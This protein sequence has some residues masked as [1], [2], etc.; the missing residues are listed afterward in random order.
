MRAVDF[1][2]ISSSTMRGS[3]EKEQGGRGGYG[4]EDHFE[5]FFSQNNEY[6]YYY[7]LSV[8]ET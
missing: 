6:Y 7:S 5:L 8:V 4:H 2:Q 3:L 1:R